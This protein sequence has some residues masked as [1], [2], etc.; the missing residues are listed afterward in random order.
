[1]VSYASV[2]CFFH[3]TSSHAPKKS[4]KL[5]SFLTTAYAT[6]TV[7]HR[8]LYCIQ[9]MNFFWHYIIISCTVSFF[10]LASQPSFLQDHFSYLIVIFS[11]CTSTKQGSVFYLQTLISHYPLHLFFIPH[12]GPAGET[13]IDIDQS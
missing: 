3:L 8:G 10:S 1:M 12:P 5:E 4:P 11:Y 6:S 7:H 2:A 9:N 13:G